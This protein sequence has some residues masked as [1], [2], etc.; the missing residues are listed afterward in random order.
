MFF[1]RW[2]RSATWIACGA[3]V[4]MPSAYAPAL[5]L[6]TVRTSGCPRSQAASV[7]DSRS[8]S[9]STGLR[10]PMSIRIVLYDWPRRTAKS[11]TP[12]TSMRPATG[13]CWARMSRISTSRQDGMASSAASLDPGRPA[14]ASATLTSAPVIGGVRRANGVVRPGICSENVDCGHRRLTH[15]NRRTCAITRTLRPPSGRSSS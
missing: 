15:L 14:S 8:G 4:R 11:S 2:N 7:P 9:T 13:I 10:V 3:P 6:H 1:H 5:S 12:S